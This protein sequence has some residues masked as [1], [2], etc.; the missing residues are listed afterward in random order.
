MDSASARGAS[1][2]SR[3][4]NLSRA[5][6]AAPVN[7]AGMSLTEGVWTRLVLRNGLQDAQ[8]DRTDRRGRG[9][10]HP[11]PL[12]PRRVRD[13][14]PAARGAL[15]CGTLPTARCAAARIAASSS[16]GGI[17]AEC[18]RQA[19]ERVGSRSGLSGSVIMG[20]P[21][22]ATAPVAII[23]RAAWRPHNAAGSSLSPRPP[24]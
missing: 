16:A 2:R 23:R 13:C 8:G 17:S 24:P 12:R 6:D 5:E 14:E 21:R 10:R 15:P 3:C 1:L 19:A 9:E 22:A 18:S 11:P 7:G 20:I 4:A